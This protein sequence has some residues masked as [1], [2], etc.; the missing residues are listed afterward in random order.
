MIRGVV[1]A[2]FSCFFYFFVFYIQD[3][4]CDRMAF[5]FLFRFV[6]L[7]FIPD[8]V[9]NPFFILFFIFFKVIYFE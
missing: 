7:L 8:P 2:A 5:D 1:G 4:S 9:H 3:D 6:C